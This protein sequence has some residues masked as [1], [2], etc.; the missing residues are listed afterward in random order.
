[1][2][3]IKRNAYFYKMHEIKQ[4]QLFLP[5]IQHDS[6]FLKKSLKTNIQQKYNFILNK[7]VPHGKIT[8]VFRENMELC[9]WK[10]NKAVYIASNK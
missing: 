8:Q 9:C 6:L 5:Y 4:N 2:P 3:K 10:D 7:D 1:M